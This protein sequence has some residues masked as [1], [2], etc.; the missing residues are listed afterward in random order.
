MC[1][2]KDIDR[3]E[4]SIVGLIQSKNAPSSGKLEKVKV[5]DWYRNA[6]TSWYL[7]CNAGQVP[8]AQ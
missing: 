4:G 7:F 3:M 6:E 5:V 2:M 1:A 8:F